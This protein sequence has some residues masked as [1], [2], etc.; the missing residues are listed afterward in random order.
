MPAR[1][2]SVVPACRTVMTTTRATNPNYPGQE[3]QPFALKVTALTITG[4][5]TGNAAGS[6]HQPEGVNNVHSRLSGDRF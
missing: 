4:G 2:T 6:E 3:P 5:L 1:A